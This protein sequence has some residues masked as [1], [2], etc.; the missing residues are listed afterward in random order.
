LKA[1]R[2]ERNG[3]DLK[4]RIVGDWKMKL[5]KCKIKRKKFQPPQVSKRNNQRKINLLVG[6]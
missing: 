3:C 4:I 1:N 6:D 2:T 5:E